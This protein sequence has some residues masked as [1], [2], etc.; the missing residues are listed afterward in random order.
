MSPRVGLELQDILQKAAELADEK[1]IESVTLASV[2][3][4]L[5]IRPPSLYN[6]VDGL[7]GLR[8]K[9]AVYGLNQLYDAL[10]EATIGRA[11]DDAVHSLGS[12]YITFARSHPGLYEFSLHA[13]DPEEAELR[14]VSKKI[15]SLILMVLREYDLDEEASLHVVRGLRSII[16]GFAS[17]LEKEGFKLSLDVD[18][19]FHLLLDTY[20]AGI[21]TLKSLGK[22]KFDSK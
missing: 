8:N 5:N 22:F 21:R 10:T 18:T 16:H 14:E 6:H 11:G 2:A 20:L 12:A 7:K 1:G 4:A 15:L 3:K 9:L 17:L 13:P 19:S